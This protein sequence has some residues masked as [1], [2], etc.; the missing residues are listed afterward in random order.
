MWMTERLFSTHHDPEQIVFHLS[1]WNSGAD[2]LEVMT[3]RLSM[4]KSDVQGL[5]SYPH[6]SAWA[7]GS[8]VVTCSSIRSDLYRESMSI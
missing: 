5:A 6:C 2:L 7:H 8:H 4:S 3:V 1:S